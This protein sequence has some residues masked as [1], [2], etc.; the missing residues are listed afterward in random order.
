MWTVIIS[1]V[2][3]GLLLI[4]LEILVIPGSGIAGVFGFLLMV[5]GVWLAYDHHGTPAGHY[6]LIATILLNLIAL[7]Y[8]LR[9]KSWDKAMLKTTVSSKV[10]E[11]EAESVKPGDTGTTISRCTPI[12]K[13]IINGTFYEVHARSEFIPED[14]AVEVI[15][16][17]RNRIFIK[18]KQ[19]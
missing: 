2:V 16:V 3:V 6:I 9:A 12:G 10:N 5:T 14:T 17:E 18:L 4:L 19:S 13:A 15:K 7:S 11:I 1:L 8:A